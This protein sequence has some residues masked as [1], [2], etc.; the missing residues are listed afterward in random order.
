MDMDAKREYAKGIIRDLAAKGVYSKYDISDVQAADQYELARRMAEGLDGDVDYDE[1]D[2]E[3]F[4]ISNR[5]VD[6]DET[7]AEGK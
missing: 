6:D 5:D 2:G 1:I 3:F 4:V 7:E